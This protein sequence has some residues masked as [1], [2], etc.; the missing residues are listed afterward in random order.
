MI[1]PSPKGKREVGRRRSVLDHS[2]PKGLVG[3]LH[4][5]NL[6]VTTPSFSAPSSPPFPLRLVPHYEEEGGRREG[7]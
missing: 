1:H 5:R 3:F 2:R 4:N 6:C 7:G